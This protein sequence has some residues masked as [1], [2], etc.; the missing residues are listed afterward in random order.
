MRGEKGFLADQKQSPNRRVA[1]GHPSGGSASLDK[2]LPSAVY[3]VSYLHCISKPFEVV[4]PVSSV[5][6]FK[7]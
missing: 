2:L 7:L 4:H 1:G 6:F 5:I 3:M